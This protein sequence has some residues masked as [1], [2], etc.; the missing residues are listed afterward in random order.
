MNNIV[1]ICCDDPYVP[2]AIIALNLFIKH[3]P[4]YSKKIIGTCFTP[5]KI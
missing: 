3:N 1:I 4:G 5:L 2:K